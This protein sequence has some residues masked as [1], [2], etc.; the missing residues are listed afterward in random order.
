MRNMARIF[1]SYR[2][3]SINN[4]SL[5]TNVDLEYVSFIQNCIIHLGKPCRYKSSD[6]QFR[7]V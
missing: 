2:E 3:R 1:G 4:V 6:V 7:I 5:N